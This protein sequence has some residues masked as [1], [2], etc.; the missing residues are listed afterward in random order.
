MID[1]LNKLIEVV[2][3]D[4]LLTLLAIAIVM[5]AILTACMYLIY[6]ER[7]LSAWMQ[8]RIGPNRVGPFGLLQPVADGLKFLLKEEV[9]PG[10][11]D[12]VMFVMAPTITVF[13]T[14]LAFS[15]IP[16]GDL[17]NSPPWIRFIIAPGVD[18]GIV[19]IFAIT[20]LAVYGVI[21]GGW[22]SNNKY[23]ALGS[24]RASA[25]VISY[26]LPLGMSILGIALL[27]STLNL[28]TIQMNQ[29]NAGIAGWNVWVQPLA[30]LIFFIS[31]L[32]ESNRLPFDLSECEQE[33]IGGFHTE[34]S[35][36]KFGLFFLGEYTHVITGAFLTVILFFG[37][38]SFPWIAEPTSVYAGAW[39]VKVGV[40][41][42]KVGLVIV[43]IMLLR[44]TI[45]R[46]RFDQLMG[47]AWKVLIPLAL[48]NVL[49]VMTVLQFHWSKWW[50][51]PSSLALIGIASVIS[52]SSK[53]KELKHRVRAHH[54]S[55]ESGGH[56]AIGHSHG[57]HAELASH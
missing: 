21:L 31:A 33:L 43:L 9:I 15:V 2:G 42:A 47:L 5:G 41:L 4:N 23:S 49:L 40:L 36:L 46:F 20:S 35:A 16:F 8:D 13:T 14:F 3:K 44:W 34:Y 39:L 32:A 53:Q 10:H 28:E 51:F 55:G 37:G 6:L 30:C 7:K 29:A 11:V 27:N 54:S 26:E 19:F 25:Q 57:V 12:K 48:G 18:I 56:P 45:P 38:W 1:L 22:A 24:L 52:V 50:L 17:T